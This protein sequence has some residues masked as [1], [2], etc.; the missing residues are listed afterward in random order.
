MFTVKAEKPNVDSPLVVARVNGNN[1]AVL[2]PLFAIVVG[3][4]ALLFPSVQIEYTVE[5]PTVEVRRSNVCMDQPG[6]IFVRRISTYGGEPERL[7]DN[8][9]SFHLSSSI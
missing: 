2:F 6:R 7:E 4:S 8:A 5:A 9:I 1:K 3:G